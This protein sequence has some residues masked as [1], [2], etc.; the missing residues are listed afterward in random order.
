MS[1][2]SKQEG[3][4]PRAAAQGNA[5]PIDHTVLDRLLCDDQEA[6]GVVL[7]QFRASCP[8]DASALGVALSRNDSK[9][10]LRWA[11]RLK[12]ACQMVGALS[13][14][15]VC[16]RIEAAVRMGDSR[17]VAGAVADIDREV[18]RITGYLDA[19]LSASP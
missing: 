7:R 12:G 5:G 10:A 13:L 19:W 2:M 16:E 4:Q 18:Q 1:R 14:A 6:V 17:Q 11:H 8:G 9:G 15:D 3:A